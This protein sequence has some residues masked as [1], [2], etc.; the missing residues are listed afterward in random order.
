M[1]EYLKNIIPRIQK[2]SKQLDQTEVFVDKTW[3]LFEVGSNTAN[4]VYV[5]PR[6]K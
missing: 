6:Q 2:A 3:E 5:S 1:I 4:R